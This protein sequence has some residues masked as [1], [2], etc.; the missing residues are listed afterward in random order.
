MSKPA[1]SD[2]K[3]PDQTA[4]ENDLASEDHVRICITCAL[5][6]ALNGVAEARGTPTV[7]AKEAVLALG[8]VVGHMVATARMC[9]KDAQY[10]VELLQH[11]GEGIADGERT[12]M[13]AGDGSARVH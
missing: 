10:L 7:P 8:H 6:N 5:F 4:P 1:K 2:Q 3:N 11:L 12:T 13:E 9:G